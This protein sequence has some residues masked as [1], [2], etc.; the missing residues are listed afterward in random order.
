[1][2]ERWDLVL[3]DTSKFDQP[4]SLF[5]FAY[6]S[7]AGIANLSFG[8][9]LI[10]NY[11]LLE[12]LTDAQA[13]FLFSLEMAG[14][15]LSS[16]IVFAILTRVC[17]QHILLS[18]IVIVVLANILSTW[19]HGY[20][21]LMKVR[22]LAGLGSGLIM[23]MTMVSIGL[24]SNIDRNYGFWT[25]AQLVVGATGLFLLP[26][27]IAELGIAAIY[28]CIVVIALPVLFLVKRFPRHGREVDGDSSQLSM[29]LLGISGLVGIFI[30]YSG[31]AAV[32]AFIERIGIEAGFQAT[33]IGSVLS[34]SLIAAIVSAVS[35]TWLSDRHGRRVPI[36]M[37]MLCSAVG[38]SLLWE[39]SSLSSFTLAACLFNAAWYF[40]LPYITA[41]IA[42]IDR[43]GRLLVG[44]SVVF[45]GSLAAGP[46]FASLLLSS[47]GYIP[48]LLI[49]LLSLPLGLIIMWKAAGAQSL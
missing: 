41:V 22:F 42:N 4:L 7:A 14:V 5:A 40:C 18:G 11:V 36:I 23:N 49:G 45:P 21:D 27:F 39:T 44:L 19:T 1:M 20:A 13:G 24:T 32:W 3:K 9:L 43:D 17:W 48:V 46:A 12:N 47:D 16:F 31:Q 29:V 30:Y 6:A 2:G 25:V 10:G 15:T 37:S 34:L 35:A 26:F 38:I 33:S 28:L 8:P